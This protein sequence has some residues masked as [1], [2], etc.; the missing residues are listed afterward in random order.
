MDILILLPF[1]LM[2]RYFVR[3]TLKPVVENMD[4]MAHFINDAGHELK[5]PL[6]II[7]GNLQILRD[8]KKPEE[9]IIETSIKAIG[10]MGDS[11]DGLLELTRITLPKIKSPIPLLESIEEIVE[12]F[13]KEIDDKKISLEIKV[14]KTTKISIDRKHFSI[15]FSN[16][17]ENA[18]RYNSIG[19]SIEVSYVSGTLSIKDTGIGMTE[20]N[21]KKIFDRFF[22][23]DRS[24]K[25]EG[26]GIG[27][28]IVDRI[29][30]LYG[31][32]ISVSSEI[33]KGTN[34]SIVVK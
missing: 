5:T 12:L 2:G 29:I 22:R 31:W 26:S 9:D 16:L 3:Q 34:F 19:G 7:S 23:V 4:A 32:K 17:V 21:R 13:R 15:L 11:L 25:Y 18:I 10:S 8:S 33:G 20:E 30:R 6:A 28:A 24:G 14:P 27:L 1:W